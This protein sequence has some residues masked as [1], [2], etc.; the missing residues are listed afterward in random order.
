VDPAGVAAAVGAVVVPGWAV[1]V[2]EVSLS[3]R[4]DEAAIGRA[5]DR[6]ERSERVAL[7]AQV[8]AAR[9]DTTEGGAAA[10]AAWREALLDVAD[11]HDLLGDLAGGAR[12]R[13]LARL[14]YRDID[15]LAVIVTLDIEWPFAVPL[16][17]ADGGGR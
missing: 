1:T 11:V 9:V 14:R 15:E 12:R 17:P 13:G 7:A 6:A 5:R 16:E 4:R 2:V 8:D 10:I 3:R